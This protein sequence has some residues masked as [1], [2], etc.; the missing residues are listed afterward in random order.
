MKEVLNRRN[1]NPFWAKRSSLIVLFLVP[2]AWSLGFGQ[3]VLYTYAQ[4]VAP[5]FMLKG[6]TLTGFCHDIVVELNKELK[7]SG[8]RIEYKSNQLKTISEIFSALSKGEIQVFIGAAYD[9]Q[10]RESANYLQPPLYGLREMFLVSAKE[11]EKF[12]E[13]LQVKIGVIGGTVTSESM[14]SIKV[15]QEIVA[16]KNLDEALRALDERRIDAIFYSSLILGYTI[17]ASKGKYDYLIIPSEKYYHY[18]VYSKNLDKTVVEKLENVVKR[19]HSEGV[20]EKLIKKYSLEQY[21]S[22]GN[23]VEILTIDWKP[24]EW[25]DP[26]KKD[27]VGV[28]VDV[29]RAVLNKMGYK[30]VFITFPWPRCV[31]LMKVG[32]YDGIMS[33]RIS[34]ERKGFLSFPEEPLSTGK[35]VLFK[36]KGSKVSINSLEGVPPET[37]CG[38]TDGYAYGDWFWNSR[39][40]KIAVPTDE[41]GFKLLQ[42]GRIELFVCNLLVGRQLAKEL[43]INVEWSPTFGE[44]MIY[45]LAFSNNYQGTLLSENFSQVLRQFKSTKEY[46]QILSKYGIT[47]EDFW[48]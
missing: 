13:K 43:G 45:Y 47:Y 35:D 42:G 8:I 31:E 12:N 29:V 32:A 7:S 6:N 4:D 27:W 37:L 40:R 18:I 30:P 16:F 15:R 21:V 3:T 23:T 20:I 39:F 1:T 19:L 36:L 5:K 22:P 26:V 9:K 10:R 2:L 46:L 17:S 34:D 44:K 25:Y 38:Y 41:V 33:L 28:D 14:P 48:K 11:K 24:Y